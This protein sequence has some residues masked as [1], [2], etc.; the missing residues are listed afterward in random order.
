M[1]YL[2]LGIIGIVWGAGIIV[3]GMLNGN[4]QTGNQVYQTGQNTG[5]IFGAI[6]IVAGILAIV[7]WKK[8]KTKT[9]EP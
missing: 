4:P 5:L 1:K 6:L 3:N 2:I 7:K 8:D 9:K